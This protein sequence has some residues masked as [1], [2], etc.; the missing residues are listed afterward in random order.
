V[1]RAPYF[2]VDGPIEFVFNTIE[3]ALGSYFYTVRTDAELVQAVN[4]VIG[5]IATFVP[6]FV[7]C[8]YT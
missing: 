3:Q 8:G 7:N 1:F 4:T 2:P 5:Q 6:Y